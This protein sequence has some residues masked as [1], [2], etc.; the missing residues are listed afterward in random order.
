MV[1]KIVLIEQLARTIFRNQS[2]FSV[3]YIIHKVFAVLTHVFA[4][5]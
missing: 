3:F 1:H 2:A 4:S 5:L